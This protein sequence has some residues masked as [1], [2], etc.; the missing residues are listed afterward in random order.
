MSLIKSSAA[1]L[2]VLGLQLTA[3][4][5]TPGTRKQ[6]LAASAARTTE[7]MCVAKNSAV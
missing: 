4:A 6:P 1:M 2:I 5:Q 7:T 3:N